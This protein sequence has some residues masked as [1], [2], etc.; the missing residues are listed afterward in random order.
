MQLRSCIRQDES[1]VPNATGDAHTVSDRISPAAHL[2]HW[3]HRF[4]H[5]THQVTRTINEV[6][7]KSHI[8]RSENTGVYTLTSI[9]SQTCYLRPSE[10][11]KRLSH[12]NT[13]DFSTTL[14]PKGTFLQHG[15]AKLNTNKTAND[16]KALKK[17]R[18]KGP[19]LQH[20]LPKK[21]IK[22]GLQLTA[23]NANTP[24]SVRTSSLP[25]VTTSTQVLPS[26]FYSGKKE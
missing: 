17:N 25:E 9:T 20:L 18:Q 2:S 7:K 24:A 6:L 8:H 22:R 21:R 16:H 11:G 3:S 1:T 14:V 19:S 23:V 13:S 5:C 12:A 4:S 26:H 10:P 15:Y